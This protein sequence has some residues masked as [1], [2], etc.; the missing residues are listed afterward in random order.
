MGKFSQLCVATS[1]AL[2]AMVAVSTARAE[3][4]YKFVSNANVYDAYQHSWWN[5]TADLFANGNYSSASRFYAGVFDSATY[6]NGELFATGSV[7]VDQNEDYR[8]APSPTLYMK[9]LTDIDGK[10]VGAAT[11]TAVANKY[12]IAFLVNEYMQQVAMQDYHTETSLFDMFNVN[13]PSL[14]KR[15]G[16]VSAGFQAAVWQ[17]WGLDSTASG[18]VATARD[19]FVA[20]ANEAPTEM[21][22]VQYNVWWL[23]DNDTSGNGYST[24][25]VFQNQLLWTDA[26]IPEPAFYQMSALLLLGGLGALRMRRRK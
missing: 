20:R 21:L 12:K 2:L 22:N 7:C 13:A 15:A 17:L 23:Y 14:T 5:S 25:S 4:V 18:D 11:K 1:V 9:R 10:E 24:R 16:Y 19:W 3:D 6:K 8:S 26:P